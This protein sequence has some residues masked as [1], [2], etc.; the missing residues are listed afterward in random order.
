MSQVK[1]LWALLRSGKPFFI[2]EAG[3]N[4]LGSLELGERLIREAAEAGAHA[5]KFQSYK[6]SNLCTKDAPRFWDWEG[7]IEEDGSQFDSYS[8]L[9]SFGEAEHA[10]L[11]R[12]CDEYDIEFMSTPFDDDATDYLDKVG[13]NA[14]KIA[15]CDVTNHPLLKHVGSK[16]KIV[17]LSTGAASLK[18]IQEAVHVLEKAGTDKI[19]IMHC[20]LKYPTDPDQINL[21]MI[22]SIQERFGDGYAYGLSDHTMTVETPAF[23]LMLGANIVEKHYTVDKTLDK[24][25]DH[26][27]S[28]DPG[29]VKEIVRLMDLSYTM[30]GT[31]EIKKC[32][33]S[34]ERAKLY[35]RRSVVSLRP[36]KAGEIFTVEN[37]GCKRPGTGISPKMFENI[38]GT[39]AAQDIEDDTLLTMSDLWTI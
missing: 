8:H 16:G 25:A 18:D 22:K 6:A 23:S 19:V 4:H 10:E 37:I 29:Q 1:S 13:I 3:V 38:L 31:S 9:D 21:S 11:K 17:M 35:A 7:E 28:V 36:I 14:Y 27:L 12:M 2:A 34:E 33:E 15:S 26:W 5:I 30:L 20:N 32:T 39:A 24:S